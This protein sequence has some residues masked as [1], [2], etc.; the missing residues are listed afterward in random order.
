MC[1]KLQSII[2]REELTLDSEKLARY[3]SKSANTEQLLQLIDDVKHELA[4]KADN[5]ELNVI[6]KFAEILKERLKNNNK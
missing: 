6:Y 2:E 5:D 1:K 4:N 3:I